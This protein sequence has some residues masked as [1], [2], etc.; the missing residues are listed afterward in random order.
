MA[1][2]CGVAGILVTWFFV[3][4][5]TG[6]DLALEDERFRAYLVGHG[7]TGEMGEEDLVGLAQEG[8]DPGLVKEVVGEK[9]SS[10]D[11]IEEGGRGE[12]GSGNGTE[13]L[14]EKL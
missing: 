7:W 14:T 9:A 6:D 10:A 1:A 8:V 5:L 4:D 12:K 11:A 13:T 3:R 2:I